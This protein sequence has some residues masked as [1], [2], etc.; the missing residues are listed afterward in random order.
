[1]S[2][3]SEEAPVV[4]TGQ[5]DSQF[6]AVSLT[7]DPTA[8]EAE[9]LQRKDEK[10]TDKLEWPKPD[11][12]E[13]HIEKIKAAM[14]RMG[15]ARNAVFEIGDLLVSAKRE[16]ADKKYQLLLK[17]TGLNSTSNADNYIRVAGAGQLRRASFQRHLPIGVGALIDLVKWHSNEIRAAIKAGVMYPDAKRSD[18]RAWILKHRGKEKQAG[19]EQPILLIYGQ[20]Y[21]WTDEDQTE[22]E[23][24]VK[25]KYTH[26][27]KLVR[28]KTPQDKYFEAMGNW[29][30]KVNKKLVQSI[31]N[32]VTIAKKA[33]GK[34]WVKQW[35]AELDLQPDA[36][37]DTMRWV[38]AH[39]GQEDRFETLR[40]AAIQAVDQPDP[41]KWGL[42][43]EPEPP[44]AAAPPAEPEINDEEAEMFRSLGPTSHGGE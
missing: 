2:N 40:E 15:E 44:A 26:K 31:R 14:G 11:D 22:L 27:L 23:K 33:K 34:D 13:T 16:F 1:M 18:L 32:L 12:L 24:F 25:Q 37:E 35:K 38:L 5:A 28:P 17:E 30:K 19:K 10:Q 36:T 21:P 9:A 7:I 6:G 3:S 4:S 41:A 42:D 39:I 20:T 43:K 8:V 29:S